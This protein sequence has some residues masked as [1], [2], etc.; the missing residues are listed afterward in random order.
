MWI[1]FALIP[2]LP[3]LCR[4]PFERLTFFCLFVHD[5]EIELHPLVQPLLLDDSSL[6]VEQLD[7]GAGERHRVVRLCRLELEFHRGRHLGIK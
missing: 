4:T 1:W 6:Q 7:A 3:T 5:G 2:L